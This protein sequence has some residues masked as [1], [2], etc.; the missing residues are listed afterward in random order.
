MEMMYAVLSVSNDECSCGNRLFREWDTAYAYMREY[1]ADSG[2]EMKI[3][4]IEVAEEE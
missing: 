4:A 1:E 2:C 3:I